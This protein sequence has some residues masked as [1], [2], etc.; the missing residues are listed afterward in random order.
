MDRA[1]LAFLTVFGLAWWLAGASAPGGSLLPV[2]ALACGA[3]AA[4]VWRTGRGLRRPGGGPLPDEVRRRF[5]GINVLQWTVISVVTAIAV[6]SGVPRL[7]PGL[8]ALVVGLHFL[9]L[10]VLFRQPRFHLTG[11]LMVA[12]GVAGCAVDLAARSAAAAR[13]IVGIGAA[14][15][16]WGT[17]CLDRHRT[18]GPAD[19]PESQRSAAA[20]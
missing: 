12:V 13:T 8:I 9:P 18:S 11:A 16:L 15:V 10:A 14:V 2:A 6:M 17:A 19:R 3:V 1:G 5:A 4:G 20:S 7:I